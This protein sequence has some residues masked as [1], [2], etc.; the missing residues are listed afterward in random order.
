[1]QQPGRAVTRRVVRIGGAFATIAVTAGAAAAQTPSKPPPT[2]PAGPRW[3]VSVHGGALIGGG[4]PK[5]T[6]NTPFPGPTFVMADGTTPTRA[7][8]SW[9]FGDGAA[10]L[11][12]VLQ[13]RGLAPRV[14][15][16]DRLPGWP[17]GTGSGFDVGARIARH[18]RGGV[19]FEASADI[20]VGGL[21]FDDASRD[22]IEATRA[23]VEAAF[24][25][26]AAS[27]PAVITASSVTSTATPASGGRQLLV[28][29]VIQYR[30]SET[31]IRP[32]LLAGVG[33]S[34]TLGSP[35][36]L[37]MTGTYRFTTPAQ[38]VIEETDT[39]RLRYDASTSLVWILG[40]G[41]M[42][43][44]SRSSAYRVELRL[45]TGSTALT[46]HLDAEPS[47][48]TAS[49][50]AVLVLNAT[51]PGIQFSSSPSVIPTL[52]AARE[53]FEAFRGEGRVYR[54]VVSVSYVR[55]F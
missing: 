19:W 34:T 29:G 17:I 21:R 3:E 27:A 47:R 53:E 9:Y 4:T 49:P 54:L 43:D 2:P 24:N 31:V 45:L 13:L 52:S 22:R 44:L 1:V 51:N 20:G 12:Q 15:P 6:S 46:A 55:R 18:L 35:A 41:V 7:V 8:A 10:L 25:A 11:N 14:D 42:H 36:T 30:G 23:D 39:M 38:A 5:G 40:G 32:V 48:I 33:V 50:G 37:T 28:S 16:L 26:L